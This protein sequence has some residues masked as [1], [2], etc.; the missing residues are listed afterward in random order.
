MEVN[1]WFKL[2][3]SNLNYSKGVCYD[4]S[5]ELW[6]STEECYLCREVNLKI[7]MNNLILIFNFQK[8]KQVLQIDAKTKNG[9]YIKVVSATHM[10]KEGKV[11]KK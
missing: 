11:Q 2:F 3:F 9:N 1:N 4:C 7:F 8:I 10:V 6:K 5:L